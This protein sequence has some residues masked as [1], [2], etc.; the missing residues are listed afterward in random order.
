[1]GFFGFGSS[2]PKYR[3][4][5]NCWYGRCGACGTEFK[6]LRFKGDWPGLRGPGNPCP[7]C[8]ERDELSFA[9]RYW[10][11]ECGTYHYVG[12]GNDDGRDYYCDRCGTTPDRSNEVNPYKY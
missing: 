8:H 4:I 11:C 2:K 1:M 3:V 7:V 10:V 5:K 9:D 6:A 12:F